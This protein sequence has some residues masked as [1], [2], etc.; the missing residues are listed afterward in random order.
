MHDDISG[1]DNWDAILVSNVFD[2]P[3]MNVV[4]RTLVQGES[5]PCALRE[6]II[7]PLELSSKSLFF[8]REVWH[9]NGKAVGHASKM[10][11]T[12]LGL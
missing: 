3:A 5:H 2:S 8:R 1:R 4:H 12:T 9:Q 11:V 6:D 10:R 7:H